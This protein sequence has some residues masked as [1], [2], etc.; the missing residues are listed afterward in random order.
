MSKHKHEAISNQIFE[1]YREGVRQIH[2]A[3]ELLTS[4][5]Y[6]VIDLKGDVITKWNIDESKK[7]NVDYNR[8]PKLPQTQ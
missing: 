3:I 4:Q 7:P 2:S 6:V 1:D 5:G 8:A